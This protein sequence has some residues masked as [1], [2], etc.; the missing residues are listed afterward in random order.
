[1]LLGEQK[2]KKNATGINSVSP[3]VQQVN[4]TDVPGIVF[5][6]GNKKNLSKVSL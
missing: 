1:M 3:A 4:N 6:G 2:T 5:P